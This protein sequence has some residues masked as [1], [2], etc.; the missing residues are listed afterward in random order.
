MSRDA[1]AEVAIPLA[2]ATDRRQA[3]ARYL[4]RKQKVNGVWGDAKKRGYPT[5]E[6]QTTAIALLAYLGEGHTD[7]AGFYQA[8]VRRALQYLTRS[9]TAAGG[10]NGMR[11]APQQVKTR[12]LVLWALSEAHAATGSS[13]YGAAAERLATALLK[14]RAANGLWPAN[15]GGSSDA[16]TTAW[17]ALA[18]KSAKG[19]GLTVPDAALVQAANA[20]RSSQKNSVEAAL[21]Y[22]L[23]GKSLSPALRR[24][25]TGKIAQQ[26]RSMTN[27]AGTESAVLQMLVARMLGAQALTQTEQAMLKALT[28]NQGNRGS[29]AGGFTYNKQ[30]PAA[31][32]ARAYL[33]LVTGNA[34]WVVLR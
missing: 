25:V 34:Q 18:L 15:P 30:N 6:L 28:K 12:A 17:A 14:L 7:R 4:L 32:S 2:N 19:A 27:A 13:R 21:V 31:A 16:T 3:V 5:D 9:V 20:L 10:L 1:A 33:L 26:N 24:S 29:E 23:A 8:Q 22:L 11:S